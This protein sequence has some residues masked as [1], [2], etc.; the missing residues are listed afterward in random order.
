VGLGFVIHGDFY[1]KP[2]RTRLMSG[3]Y[4]TWL[5]K[6]TANKAA[7]DFLTQLLDEFKPSRIFDAF[8]PN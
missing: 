4:N 7:N 2:D 1:V 5:L 8:V 6:K 3:E